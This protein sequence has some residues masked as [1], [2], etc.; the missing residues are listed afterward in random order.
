MSQGFTLR[1]KFQLG[2]TLVVAV[3]AMLLLG[4]RLLSKA[5]LFHYLER[6]HVAIVLNLA[7]ALDHAAGVGAG[8]TLDRA[9]LRKRM[10]EAQDLARR[11]DS[12]L[13]PP[14]QWAF[15]LLGFGGVLDLPRK[16]IDD[17]E[18]MREAV[19][20]A[21]GPVMPEEVAQLQKDM[22]VVLDNSNRF[23]PLVADAASFVKVSVVLIDL[24]GIG[25]LCGIFW[26][27]RAATLAPLEQALAVSKR[28]TDG[29]LAT[30]VP[31]PTDDELGDLMRALD[32]MKSRLA[33][34]VG[35]VRHR[36]EAVAH[37]LNEVATGH[38]DLS[39][40][41]EQQASTIQQTASSVVELT[42]AVEH[43][44]QNVSTAD[45][46]A[47]QAAQVAA[48]GGE[49]V[50]Q[51]VASMSQILQSSKK[52]SDIIS[53]I[54]G[55]A[56]QTNILALNAAVEAA[57]AGEQGRGFAVVAGEVRQLAQRSATAAKEIA[58]LIHDSVEKVESGAQLVT[59]AGQTMGNVVTSVQQV[60][61]LISEVNV[62]L[63]EQAAGIRQIDHAMGQLDHATQQNAALAEE[64][65]AAVDHVRQETTALVATVQQF[66]LG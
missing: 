39:S 54:D 60:S 20:A 32:Q 40:R 55:I 29:D 46:Q 13:F 33:H 26:M 17:L 22:A 51:V 10:G 3:S 2:L 36:T 21:S 35:D 42:S 41:T 14:E 43:S 44:V 23:G 1:K 34:V 27:I 7:Q 12:E 25:V 6:E 19:S 61:T 57:R 15:R 59:Q 64:S 50:N 18:R 31:R 48:Q 28:I 16:D 53:V 37:S 66:R 45:Q 47:A 30:P 62:S 65:A 8:N 9:D 49:T 24:L 52:I 58:S 11:A 5:A 63:S 4:V 38:G 56:F